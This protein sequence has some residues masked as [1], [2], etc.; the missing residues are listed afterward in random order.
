MTNQNREVMNFLPEQYDADRRLNLSHNYLS[1][2]FADH[3]LILAKVREVVIRGDFTLG[4]EVDLLEAEFARLCETKHAVSVGSGTDAI[5]LCLKAIDIQKGDEVITTPFTFYAT[6]GAI[7]AAGGTPVFADIGDDYN[8]DPKKIEQKITDKTKCIVPVHWAGR[9]C[10]LDQLE[11]LAESVGIPIISDACHAVMAAY[12]GI[13]VAKWGLASCFSFH[14]LKNLNIW[15]DGG[16][17]ATDSADLARA[18]RLLRNHGLIS[19]DRCERFG[20]NSRLDTIQAVVARHMLPKLEHITTSRISN[21][22]YFDEKLHLIRG[23]SVPRRDS[24]EKEVFHL[25]SV[26]CD[27]RDNL[28][29]FLIGRGIDAKIHYPIPMHLQPAS[30]FLGYRFGDFTKAERTAA[31]T[32]S[33]PVHEFMSRAQQDYIVAAIE[34]FY[35]DV[36]Y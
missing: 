9:P 34:E 23:V 10:A 15:G 19:R 31:A 28:Q 6:V 8:I 4:G 33:L 1:P 3:D 32:L 30:A 36:C 29:K 13:P 22:K 25:Y 2:Q 5:F 12:Q 16:M 24:R 14:P 35:G 26:L 11:A 17:V 20:Y 18:L 7:V 27:D 21:S